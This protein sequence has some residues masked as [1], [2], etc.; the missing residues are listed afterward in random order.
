MENHATGGWH[1]TP[2][3][4]RTNARRWLVTVACGLGLVVSSAGLA[5]AEADVE[6]GK[7]VTVLKNESVV[8][9]RGFTENEPVTVELVRDGA[10]VASSSGVASTPAPGGGFAFEVNRE[11]TTQCWAS[12]TPVMQGGDHVVVKAS[13]VQVADVTVSDVDIVDRPERI[14]ADSAIVRGDVFGTP[15]PPISELV[16]DTDNKEPDVS[17][18]A[19]GDGT[20]TYDGEGGAFT[21]RFDGLSPQQMNGL[22]QSQDVK[23]TH[24]S[25]EG[26]A[27]ESR[28]DSTADQEETCPPVVQRGVVDT[29]AGNRVVNRDNV[30][31][32]LVIYG[33]NAPGDFVEVSIT[34]SGGGPEP[35]PVA[36][37]AVSPTTWEV[38]FPA[39]AIEALGDG[40]LTVTSSF[41]VAGIKMGGTRLR[42]LKDTKTPPAP[43]VSP[44]GGV[45][46]GKR[47]VTLGSPEQD[48]R[49]YY[50]TEG[51]SPVDD[52]DAGEYGKP[53]AINRSAKVRAVAVDRAGNYSAERSGSFTRATVPSAP[54]IRV[55]SSGRKGRP[56]TAIARWL[57]PA[58]SGGVKVLRYELSAERISGGRVVQRRTYVRASYVRTTQLVLPRG[59]WRFRVRAVNAVGRSSWSTF[60]NRVTAR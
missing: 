22:L 8:S 51:T 58:K 20:L 23:V 47:T 28:H 49:V 21:A 2:T 9:A 15:R 59:T 6:A 55:A 45:F 50:T 14:D 44:A 60:S 26:E 3:R 37:N 39:E 34:S 54:R 31:E 42:L 24:R 36:A 29:E 18:G 40:T 38:E 53:L 27:T 7:S 16:V 48:A 25:G 13:G 5:P 52:Y 10:T 17:L 57:P 12:A 32:P 46:I 30:D 41:T 33:D 1:P 11:R 4:S 19:P 35:E 43:T 56:V